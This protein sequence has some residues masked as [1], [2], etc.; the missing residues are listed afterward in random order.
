MSFPAGF[1]MVPLLK[2]VLDGVAEKV[3]ENKRLLRMSKTS[4]IGDQLVELG[5]NQCIHSV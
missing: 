5:S 3:L 1:G 4:I 2:D